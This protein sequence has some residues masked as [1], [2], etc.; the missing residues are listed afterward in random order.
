[1]NKETLLSKQ[2]E[3]SQ[4]FDSVREQKEALEV[5]LVKLQG[6]YRL[7]SELV[8]IFEEPKPKRSNNGK[9]TRA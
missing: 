4:R 2:A 7:L 6:E 1:M 5:E 3:V 8:A 9:R